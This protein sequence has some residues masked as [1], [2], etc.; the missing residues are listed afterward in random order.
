MPST[1]PETI[2]RSGYAAFA[3]G[4]LDTIRSISSPDIR[5]RVPGHH[6]LSGEK[7][8]IDATLEYFSQLFARTGGTFTATPRRLAVEDQCVFVL[9]DTAGSRDGASIDVEACIVFE[10]ANGSISR[11]REFFHDQNAVDR[12]FA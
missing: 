7:V 3:A 4:D 6:V 5:W 11:V 9:Q 10:V 8:G 1:E 12:F 2:V